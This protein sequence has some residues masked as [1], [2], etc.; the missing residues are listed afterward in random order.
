MGQ[1]S[2]YDQLSEALGRLNET[3][4]FSVWR[5]RKRAVRGVGPLM[6][7]LKKHIHATPF[8][9][10]QGFQ[11]ELSAAWKTIKQR[12]DVIHV[13]YLED[14]LG[15]LPYLRKKFF[16]GVKLVATAHQPPSW[17]KVNRLAPYWLNELDA[18]IVLDSVSEAFF[19]KYMSPEKI[20]VVPHGVAVD[21][22]TPPTDTKMSGKCLYVGQW[23]RDIACL[24]EVVRLVSEKTDTISFD[25]VFKPQVHDA[26][27]PLLLKLAQNPQV[28]FHPGLTDTQLANLYR[29]AALLTLPLLD[30]SANNALLEA[31]AS[32]LPI[33]STGVG[34]V[35]EYVP[36]AGARIFQDNKPELFAEA[37]LHLIAQ[38]SER[39]RM[40][41]VLREKAEEAYAWP[42]VAG[43][44]EQLYKKLTGMSL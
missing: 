38:P 20:H 29:E 27:N 21:F 34:G 14:T 36:A 39:I 6:R 41:Q 17:W 24:E 42:L 28:T 31:M 37:I 5:N 19:A 16:P 40:G 43:Q 8:Y 26:T 11:M 1:Y 44:M 15:V 23:L 32:G 35:K 10:V 25:L 33:L 9:K 12:V 13:L 30:S 4:I 2:G 22:F 18:L 7:F 3:T